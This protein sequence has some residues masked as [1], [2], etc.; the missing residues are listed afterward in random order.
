MFEKENII[1]RSTNKLNDFATLHSM[2]THTL[3]VKSP[4]RESSHLSDE[5]N[6]E[7]LALVELLQCL[8]NVVKDNKTFNV[9]SDTLCIDKD[10]DGN[11]SARIQG[12][13]V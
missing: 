6:S 5:P 3:I 11:L 7:S 12:Q 10:D 8:I 9:F 4:G 1:V 13:K 2:F